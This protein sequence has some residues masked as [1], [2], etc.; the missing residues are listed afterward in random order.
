[1]TSSRLHCAFTFVTPIRQALRQQP[2]LSVKVRKARHDRSTH[3]D[4]SMEPGNIQTVERLQPNGP[5]FS[6]GIHSLGFRRPLLRHPDFQ[7]FPE[8]Q[9]SPI[10]LQSSRSMTNSNPTHNTRYST[11]PNSKQCLTSRAFAVLA[12]AATTRSAIYR[13]VSAG[14]SWLVDRS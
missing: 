10:L 2:A 9:L 8:L 13:A 14:R 12:Q 1:M 5:V 7:G 6:I 11:T 3:F 4:R